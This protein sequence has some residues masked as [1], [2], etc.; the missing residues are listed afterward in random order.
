MQRWAHDNLQLEGTPRAKCACQRTLETRVRVCLCSLSLPDLQT[1][2]V[3]SA[4]DGAPWRLLMRV[5]RAR[6][7]ECVQRVP[8]DKWGPSALSRYH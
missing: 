1:P 8:D 2:H 6:E 3:I 5:S 7:S 4:A